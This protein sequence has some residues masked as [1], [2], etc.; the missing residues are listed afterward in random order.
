MIKR[1]VIVSGVLALAAAVA[2]A[3]D[4]PASQPAGALSLRVDNPESIRGAASW[5]V[6]VTVLA[7]AP[8][9]AVLATCFTRVAVVLGLLRQALTTH[10]V[11][12]NQVLLGLSLLITFVVMTPVL[13]GVHADAVGP[14]MAGKI[15][16]MGAVGAGKPHVRGF[17]IRQI[18]AAG[19]DEDVFLFIPKDLRAREDL[20]WADVPTPSLI[21]GYVISELKVAFMIGLRVFLPFVIVDMLVATVL[22]S[23]GMLMLPP[24]LISLPLKLL[25]FV[26][27]DGWHLVAGT[28]LTSLGYA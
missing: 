12:P 25:L 13:S 5:V 28:L 21:A 22:T 15:D 4:A 1:L 14:Y 3:A 6:V 27:A 16:A 26:L 8:A 23:M 20:K 11:P 9:I 2:V 10:Q 18:E 7:V 24:V 19:N 17:M